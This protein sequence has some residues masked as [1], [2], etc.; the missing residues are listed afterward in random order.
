M[1]KEKITLTQNIAFMGIVAAINVICSV[2]GAL[3]P[4]ASI[5]IIIFLP[6]FS[7]TVSL[8]CKWKYYPIYF[9]ASIGVALGATFWN[10]QYTVFYLIPSL[11]TGFIF[12]FC[13]KKHL[14]G[15]Y[16]ILFA[17]IAQLA[18]SYALIPLINLI[19][20]TDIINQFLRMMKLDNK[21]FA[22]IMIPSFIFLISLI[23][24]IFSFIV[25]NNE[26]NK[27]KKDNWSKDNKYL[28][29]GG[30]I[31]SLLLIPF[32]FFA[33]NVAYLFMFICLFVSISSFIDLI[34]LN[35]NKVWLIIILSILMA[36]GFLCI[37]IFYNLLRMPYT[38]ILINVSNIS[39]FI[40]T[41]VYNLKREKELC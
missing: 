19:Y 22:Y 21:Q 29:Y 3:F 13:F 14:S 38:L 34:L 17:S 10:T 35:K 23:Q 33:L 9:F 15:S 4:I 18:I 11:I 24:M 8:L 7:A 1:F 25:L 37:F 12:G 40:F 5:F 27:L 2:L 26:L 36:S 32:I 6:F 20:N 28:N 39:I 41:L 31:L 30:A 16:A